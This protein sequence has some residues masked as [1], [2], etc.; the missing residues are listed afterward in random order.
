VYAPPRVVYAIHVTVV[1][2]EKV[3]DRIGDPYDEK[4]SRKSLKFSLGK[5]FRSEVRYA[6]SHPSE[7]WKANCNNP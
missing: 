2:A 6:R 4:A 5:S 3:A 7:T 1:M